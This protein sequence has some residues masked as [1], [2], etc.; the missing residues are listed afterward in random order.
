MIHLNKKIIIYYFLSII[1]IF[2]VI[3]FIYNII[4]LNNKNMFQN[5]IDKLK[6][7]SDNLIKVPKKIINNLNKIF[8]ESKKTEI[9]F[10][11][12]TSNLLNDNEKQTLDDLI[13]SYT[14]SNKMETKIRS[15]KRINTVQYKFK[16]TNVNLFLY[17]NRLSKKLLNELLDLINFSIT[18]FD[19]I[20]KPRKNVKIYFLLTNEKKT[21]NIEKNNQL[22][23]DN[24]NTGYTQS[25]SDINE[26]FIVI[27]RMEELKKVLVHELIHLYNL[28]GFMRPS[29]VKINTL[30]KSTNTRFS[31]FEAYTET[32]AILIYTYY[33]SKKNNEDFEKL[34]NKQL[35]FSFLQSAK[36]LY[37]QKIYNVNDL[38]KKE[39]NETTNA[40]SYFI[41]KCA[42]L[43]NINLYKNIFN[44]KL[45]ISLLNKEEIILFDEN[46]IKSI[47]NKKFKENIN[48][49]LEELKNNKVDNILLK[50]FRMNILD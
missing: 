1:A 26:D 8:D 38:G 19:K 30:I 3:F 5:E 47:K 25:F 32:L 11:K 13:N 31:I 2:L 49:Y 39:I 6:Y 40:T 34:I 35:N 46:L 10:I 7:P 28:H 4:K 37:N 16:D 42:I 24:I 20:H 15:L 44:E 48:N 29:N 23:G 14:Y 17:N 22:I 36:I 41:I 27:Y 33:Y 18:L 43:S 45:G 50:S 21:I 12:N 9:K